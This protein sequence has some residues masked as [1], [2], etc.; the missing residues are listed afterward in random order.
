MNKFM[1]LFLGGAVFGAS[2]VVLLLVSGALD[3]APESGSLSDARGLRPGRQYD[4]PMPDV[5]LNEL[6]DAIAA[7]NS[8]AASL[9]RSAEKF[10]SPSFASTIENNPDYEASSGTQTSPFA[11]QMPTLSNLGTAPAP[12][13]AHVVQQGQQWAPPTPEQ[14]EHYYSLQ[15]RLYNAAYDHSAVLTELNQES[16]ELTP[17][18]RQELVNEALEMIKRGELKAEQFM[19]QPEP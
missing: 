15:S 19:P 13:A 7:L 18:Q 4:S 8:V 16:N 6:S 1:M 17:A 5:Q 10:N 12:G 2:V 3:H 14:V 9:Q 11:D